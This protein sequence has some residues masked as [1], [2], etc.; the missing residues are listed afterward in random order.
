MS[1]F[2]RAFEENELDR[3]FGQLLMKSKDEDD[4]TAEI[5]ADGGD[6]PVQQVDDEY[7]SE[8]ETESEPQDEVEEIW[9]NDFVAASRFLWKSWSPQ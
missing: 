6:V 2:Q 8:S 5:D 4:Q 3:S 1:S 7:E 9:T